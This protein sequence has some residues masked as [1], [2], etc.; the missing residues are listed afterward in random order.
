[1][2]GVYS[3]LESAEPIVNFSPAECLSYSEIILRA[4]ELTPFLRQEVKHKRF[5][6]LYSDPCDTL[7]M[8]YAALLAEQIAILQAPLSSPEE[9]QYLEALMQ[10]S[11]IQAVVTSH[12]L[13]SCLDNYAPGLAQ[14]TEVI[15]FS[16]QQARKK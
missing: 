3:P 12:E 10:K 7:I 8:T 11:G 5:V 13:K 14:K 16:P 9:G 2:V 15:S 6:M 1:M 4:S